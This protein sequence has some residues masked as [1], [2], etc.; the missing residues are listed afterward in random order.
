MT[1]SSAR[2]PSWWLVICVS[3]LIAMAAQPANSQQSFKSPHEAVDV[4]IAAA[5][6]DSDDRAIAVLGSQG[7][8]IISSG[9]IVADKAARTN[10]LSNFEAKHKIVLEGDNK[11][12]LV[13]GSGDW[14]FPIPMIRKDGAWQFDTE[15]GRREIL[16]RRIG[17]NELDAIQVCL[18]YVDAQNE[19]AAADPQGTDLHA[20]AQRI[21]STPGKR[22]GLYWPD[23]QGSPKSPLGELV[24]RA[25]AAGYRTDK[26]VPFHGYYYRILTGQGPAASGGAYDYVVRGKMIGGFALLAYPA[27]YG[28]SGVMTFVVNHDGAIYQKD[29]G[30]NTDRVASDIKLFNPDHTWKRVESAA[31]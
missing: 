27:R 12:V 31:K 25:S 7:R 13:I 1:V 23:V 16:Y 3:A 15:S 29:L 14:P 10:F 22:D 17:S 24:A 11:A 5:K 9:D 20:Y 26:Q 18:A 8:D 4:L 28:N 30:P 19:Y 6:A 2:R 21:V